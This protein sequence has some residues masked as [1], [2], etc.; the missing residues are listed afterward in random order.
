MKPAEKILTAW[1]GKLLSTGA[2]V[3]LE[4]VIRLAKGLWMSALTGKLSKPCSTEFNRGF[5]T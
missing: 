2:F 4:V 3:F 5:L 1:S